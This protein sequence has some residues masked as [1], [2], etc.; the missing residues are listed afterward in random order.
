MKPHDI[1]GRRIVQPILAGQHSG[2]HSQREPEVRLLSAGFAD[3][4]ARGDT[5]DGQGGLAHRDGLAEHV[6]AAAEASLP[7]VVTQDGGGCPGAVLG[8]REYPADRGANAESLKE[9][10]GY[11]PATG[12]FPLA[13]IE[14][15]LPG[16]E[17]ALRSHHR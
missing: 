15:D 1:G 9:S 17:A 5:D 6:E 2:L 3:K 8:R 14:A 12:F 4:A 7:V 16:A 13:I 10:T 11:Q